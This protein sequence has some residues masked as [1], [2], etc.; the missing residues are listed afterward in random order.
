MHNPSSKFEPLIRVKASDRHF[1]V[2]VGYRTSQAFYTCS[3]IFGVSGEK[4]LAQAAEL[5][6]W[7]QQEV[8]NQDAARLLEEAANKL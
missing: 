8:S 5:K 4:V 7:Y 2:S 1:N 3:S 6:T